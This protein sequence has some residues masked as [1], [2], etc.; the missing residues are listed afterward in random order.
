MVWLAKMVRRPRRR[1]LM[2]ASDAPA[3]P[4]EQMHVMFGLQ[5]RDGVGD[6]RLGQVQR[7]RGRRHMLTLG[8]GD[9]DAQAFQGHDQS[10]NRIET[11]I[12]I[13]WTGVEGP[14]IKLD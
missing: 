8:H 14:P 3:D 2:S 13:R 9:E 10:P 12:T 1:A 7:P 4:V 11:T 5:R 6:R